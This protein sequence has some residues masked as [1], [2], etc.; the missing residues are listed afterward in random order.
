MTNQNLN[1]VIHVI[2]P[3]RNEAPSIAKVIEQ[4]PRGLI[5]EVIVVNNGST[6]Q[7]AEVAAHSGAT[8]LNETKPGYG[9]AC[10]AGIAYCETRAPQPE[11]VVFM[12][13]DFSDYPEDMYELLQ[14]ILN[15][16]ADLV[17]GSRVLGIREK[18]SMTVPQIF[19]N[20]LATKLLKL[21]FGAQF[22]DLGPF[23]AIRFTSLLALQ[24]KD[25]TYGWTVEMQVKAA[26]K[27][28]KF[29]EV[30][31]RYRRRIGVSK[32]SG[33]VKGTIL[34]GYKILYT[35]FKHI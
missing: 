14:P 30:P 17:V 29:V 13:G 32:I 9:N 24:M 6:D 19:G 3:A 1:R 22:T 15:N 25:R 23:R 20:W 7:T 21:F 16:Q 33:T 27:K 31:V 12:D 18:G 28:L 35:I 5:S 4:I 11:I 10:L 2:I 8:V 34:A 26:R